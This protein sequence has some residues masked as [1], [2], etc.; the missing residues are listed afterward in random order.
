LRIKKPFTNKRGKKG[1]NNP[2]GTNTER[3]FL[4]YCFFAPKLVFSAMVNK[5]HIIG[6]GIAAVAA[7][8]GFLFF[9]GTNLKETADNIRV[10]LASLPKIHKI[11]LSG[12]KFPLIC[13]WTIPEKNALP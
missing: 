1:K 5:P 3:Q 7:A 8:A 13:E 6:I 12:L 4:T 9:K 10:S 2:K 11:D